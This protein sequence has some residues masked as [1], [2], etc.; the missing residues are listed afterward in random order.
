MYPLVSVT[1]VYTGMIRT[2]TKM[3][4]STSARESALMPL[5]S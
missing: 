1:R 3:Q 4:N 5:P 2:P